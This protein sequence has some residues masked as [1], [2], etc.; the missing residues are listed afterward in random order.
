MP[1]ATDFA[2][3]NAVKY[4]ELKDEHIVDIKKGL[5]LFV[6]TEEYFDKFTHHS[7]V[8]RGHKT[9][10]SRIL[11][12]PK[13]KESDIK[14]RAE[15]V[16]PRPSKIAV[17]TV[18]RTVENYSDKAIYS[19]EDL[20]YHFD[21]TVKS[22]QATLK[23]IAVQKLDWIKGRAFTKS[24]A[25]LTPELYALSTHPL[26]NTASILLTAEK[27]AIVFRKNKVKRWDG[28]HYLAHITPEGLQRLREEITAK[29]ES[30]S[31][32][33]KVELDGRTYEYYSYGDF[34]YSVCAHDVMYP[35]ESGTQKQY[36]IFMGRRQVDG[37][38]PV[39]VAK[40]EGESD[41]E[42]INNG[43]GSG[44]LVDE[45]GNTTADDNKQQGSVGIN[46]DGLGAAVTDDLCILT[47]KFTNFNTINMFATEADRSGFDA[48]GNAAMLKS[49]SGNFVELAVDATDTNVASITP[50]GYAYQD[51]VSSKY[52]GI[53][54]TIVEFDA[55][56]SNSKVADTWTAVYE[57]NK[58]AEIVALLDSGA[59]ALVRIPNNMT[60]A[61]TVK[62]T[63]KSAS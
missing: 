18:E 13:V 45:D 26:Y 55:V 16:A 61:L 24:R 35:V 3:E 41:I 23:E 19:R 17:K 33:V 34:Y 38:S 60:G 10:Q 31:D 62:V 11:I 25:I 46:M 21:D 44:V 1:S 54:S 8:P 47:C 6:P 39:D 58:N 52:Y 42:L 37:Q 15:F 48:T 53:G 22:I 5:E 32:P 57:T 12:A 9:F 36:I 50:V 2:N 14:P 43:L 40:L 51:S 59:K 49:M 28:A 56:F 30:L 20:Q 63:S 29:K 7:T 4:A 27:A